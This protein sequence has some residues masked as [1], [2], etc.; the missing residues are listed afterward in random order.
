[1]PSTSHAKCRRCGAIRH[2]HARA[3][4][5]RLC[6]LKEKA[7]KEQRWRDV[8]Q[9]RHERDARTLARAMNAPELEPEDL[10]LEPSFEEEP[11][12]PMKRIKLTDEQ[13]AEIVHL[14]T[15]TDTPVTEI[16][17]AY[18]LVDTYPFTVLNRHGISWRRGSGE[19]A[20]TRQLPPQIAA[21]S[22]VRV[23]PKPPVRA[24]EP[25]KAPAMPEPTTPVPVS[26]P[27]PDN[28]AADDFTFVLT[29]QGSLRLHAASM[30]EAI[31]QA[32]ASGLR[33]T[34]VEQE[35]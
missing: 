14:Y 31:Q 30:V 5:C 35:A 6:W 29:V 4:L 34:K 26:T 19:A 12:E 24:V 21:M 10:E 7:Q 17:R 8:K 11:D 23:E 25:Q 3:N 9:S 13:E 15:T 32:Q 22:A 16:A 18:G 28:G 2:K 33:V 27:V 20:P 1:V